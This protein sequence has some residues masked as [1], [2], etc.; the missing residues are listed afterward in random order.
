RFSSWGGAQSQCPLLGVKRTSDRMSGMSAFDPKQTLNHPFC[1]D[2]QQPFCNVVVCRP[3]GANEATGIHHLC[4][5]LSGCCLAARGARATACSRSDC[6]RAL[7]QGSHYATLA[8]LEGFMPRDEIK[9]VHSGTV[10]ERYEAMMSG[11][12]DAATLM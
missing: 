7:H 1:C 4:S 2:A 12:T 5:W 6:R 3:W 9:V 11:E 8:M 10:G